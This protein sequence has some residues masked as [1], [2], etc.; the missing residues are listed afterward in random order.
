MMSWFRLKLI[1]F[2]W[3]SRSSFGVCANRHWRNATCGPYE[4]ELIMR[5]TR[6]PNGYSREELVEMLRTIRKHEAYMGW[7]VPEPSL[8]VVPPA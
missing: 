7:R 5:D 3:P 1:M 2:L 6:Q 4:I 8:T